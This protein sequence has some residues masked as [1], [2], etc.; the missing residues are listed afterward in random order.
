MVCC[1]LIRYWKCKGVPLLI[2]HFRGTVVSTD[3]RF[4]VMVNLSPPAN[5]EAR[6]PGT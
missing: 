3:F 6:N 1:T 4:R 2:Y 5:L